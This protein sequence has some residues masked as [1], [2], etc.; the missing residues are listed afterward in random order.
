MK[1]KKKKKK[2]IQA[3]TRGKREREERPRFRPVILA[4]LLGA[5]DD[6]TRALKRDLSMEG[7]SPDE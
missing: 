1:K 2:K 3:S 5:V 7:S 4:R 6:A